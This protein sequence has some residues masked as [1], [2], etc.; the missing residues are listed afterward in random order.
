MLSDKKSF[1]LKYSGTVSA[2]FLPSKSFPESIQ[3]SIFVCINI[4]TSSI[5]KQHPNDQQSI[6][7]TVHHYSFRYY[8]PEY[9]D[10]Q[11][12]FKRAR[13]GLAE[14]SSPPNNDVRSPSDKFSL[15]KDRFTPLRVLF[16]TGD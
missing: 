7:S 12:S 8:F 14:T 5:I 13:T 10:D 16:A 11:V 1:E 6:K 4:A 9:L 15:D 2:F 3:G